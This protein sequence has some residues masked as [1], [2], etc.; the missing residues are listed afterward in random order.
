MRS[1]SAVVGLGSSL[2]VACSGQQ[3][4]LGSVRQA[5]LEAERR[6]G[7]P[8]DLIL[9][10][11]EVNT[12]LYVAQEEE[13][14]GMTPYGI[15]GIPRHRLAEAAQLAGVSEELA[16]TQDRENIF[17]AAALLARGDGL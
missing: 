2:L 3:T 16:I 17:A 14:P 13:N 10:W 7:V 12:R 1:L 6:H 11:G 15:I 8:A 5:A 9:A 4:T